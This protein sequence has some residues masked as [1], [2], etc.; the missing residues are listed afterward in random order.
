ML[1]C[2]STAL[3]PSPLQFPYIS[4]PEE[5]MEHLQRSLPPIQYDQYGKSLTASCSRAS[6]VKGFYMK[7]FRLATRVGQ[8]SVEWLE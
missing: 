7:S 6:Y 4:H 3:S 5:L 2:L 1:S 8:E